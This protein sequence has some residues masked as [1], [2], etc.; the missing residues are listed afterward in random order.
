MAKVGLVFIFA[1]LLLLKVQR[2]L[3]MK[4]EAQGRFL[5][6]IAEEYN[7]RA[8]NAKPS[9]PYSP[10]VSLPSLCEDSDSEV[11]RNAIPSSAATKFRAPKKIRIEEDDV[12]L[13]KCN[14]E[15]YSN[16]QNMLLL[17]GLNSP[18]WAHE[19]GYPWGVNVASHSPILPA[20][21]DPLN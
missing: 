4:M 13:Q 21:Y 12:L 16:H 7:N 17:K 11:D 18:C 14:S 15:S 3:K 19:M 1:S 2:S 20:L 6:R 5:D 9:K 8:A 10:A